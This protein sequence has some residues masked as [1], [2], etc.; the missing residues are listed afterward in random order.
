[1]EGQGRKRRGGRRGWGERGRGGDIEGPGM[2]S[3]PGPALALG[4][5]GTKC[6]MSPINGQCTNFIVFDVAL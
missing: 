3:A 5:P 1:M 2:W 6:I 4:G